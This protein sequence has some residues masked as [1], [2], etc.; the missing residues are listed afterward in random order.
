MQSSV[1]VLHDAVEVKREAD[2]KVGASDE[3]AYR[4]LVEFLVVMIDKNGLIVQL[5]GWSQ[6]LMS[7]GIIE[8]FEV[9]AYALVLLTLL[10][11]QVDDSLDLHF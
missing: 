4:F 10:K 11:V 7:S 6:V 5:L 2:V 9:L 8:L 1:Y 3:F